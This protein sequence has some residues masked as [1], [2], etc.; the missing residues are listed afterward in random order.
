MTQI[1]RLINLRDNFH[2]LSGHFVQSFKT[3]NE[4]KIRNVSSQ[5]HVDIKFFAECL[6][7]IVFFK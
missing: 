1:T 4:Y 2:H 5:L 7:K 6:V 3:G